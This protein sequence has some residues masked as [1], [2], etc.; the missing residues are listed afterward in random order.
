[1]LNKKT[2]SFFAAVTFSVAAVSAQPYARKIYAAPKLTPQITYIK[3]LNKIF[4]VQVANKVTLPDHVDNSK[5]IYFPPIINQEGGS[6]AQASGIAYMFTYEM[7]RL[8]GRDA[9][10]SAA[11]RFSYQFSWNMINDGIDQGSFVEQGL[12]LAERYGMMTEQDYG[13]AQTFS[14]RWATGYEKYYNALHYRT[15][16]ILTMEDSIPLIKRYLYDEGNG[17]STGGIVTFS[18]R[19]SNWTINDNYEGPSAT[20]YHSILTELATEGSHALTIAG[21][22]DLVTYTD[23]KGIV[24][25]GAFI[26]V[27]SWGTY[28]HDN[29]RFYLPYDFFRDSSIPNSQLS[30]ELNGVKVCTF[31][32]KVVFKIKVSYTSRNDLSFAIG[33]SENKAATRAVQY[34]D[35]TAFRNQG[36][37]YPMQGQWQNNNLEFAI[38]FT[39]H[40]PAQGK[41]YARYF[42]EV[43]RSFKGNSLGNGTV[44]AIS[45]IDY[46]SG[47]PKEYVCR[48]EFPFTLK[49]GDNYFTIP[50]VPL[51]IISASNFNWQTTSGNIT[52]KTFLLRTA[53]GRHAKIK[54]ATYDK[55]TGKIALQYSVLNK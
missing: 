14:F 17:S 15:S 27:N 4:N 40:Q 48:T 23:T 33:A 10:A 36:G 8:L 49:T 39:D 44:D 21:Y 41:E 53:S 2:I 24:H 19:S 18:T 47:T 55:T 9:S 38:D 31:V 12:F 46:R 42:L 22:D 3:S 6:C 51:Y 32:P 30:N 20:G 5:S 37:D 50:V 52:D 45:V 13:L 35:C 34:Y 26:V 11:N 16:E 29:G 25:K 1:M 54:V 7:N 43:D 28:M